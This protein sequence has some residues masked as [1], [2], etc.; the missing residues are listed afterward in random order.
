MRAR[1]ASFLRCVD[2]TQHTKAGRTSL[3]E[4][5]ARRKDLYLTIHNTHKTDIHALA[6]FESAIPAGERPQTLETLLAVLKAQFAM[7]G[8][9]D[10]LLAIYSFNSRKTL[11]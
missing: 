10:A 8:Q 5:S 6:G 2:H 11:C 3:D 1:V 4:G 7:T 9:E